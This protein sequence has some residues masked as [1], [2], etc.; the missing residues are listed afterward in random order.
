MAF[1]TIAY[2]IVSASGESPALFLYDRKRFDIKIAQDDAYDTM[3]RYFS[4]P[5]VHLNPGH[6]QW[7]NLGWAAQFDTILP[8]LGSVEVLSI[9]V[10]FDEIERRPTG[11]LVETPIPATYGPKARYGSAGG[12]IIVHAAEGNKYRVI[13]WPFTASI[14]RH[15]Q[16]KQGYTLQPHGIAPTGSNFAHEIVKHF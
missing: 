7:E 16:E 6:S 2:S 10:R 3:M 11:D 14:V 9:V 12:T 5:G 15:G 4:G 1:S 13:V 8:F